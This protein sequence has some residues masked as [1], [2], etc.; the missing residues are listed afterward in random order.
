M[1]IQSESELIGISRMM[2]FSEISFM[3]RDLVNLLFQ[4]FFHFEI[5]M[6]LFS[7]PPPIKILGSFPDVRL[8]AGDRGVDCGYLYTLQ[9]S[10]PELLYAE[11]SEE[12]ELSSVYALCWIRSTKVIEIEIV[13]FSLLSHLFASRLLKERNEPVNSVFYREYCDL[14]P[15]HHACKLGDLETLNVV[16]EGLSQEDLDEPDTVF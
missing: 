10:A 5:D 8:L 3:D 7:D 14:F 2:R 11:E 4:F 15:F 9:F 1:N 16:L 13:S 6:I 12:L